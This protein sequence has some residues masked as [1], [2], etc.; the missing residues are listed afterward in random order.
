MTKT[1]GVPGQRP[2]VISVSHR[3]IAPR[4]CRLAAQGFCPSPDR[5]T[6]SQI[7]A[8]IIAW[9]RHHQYS[10]IGLFLCL[11]LADVL[12]TAQKRDNKSL[13]TKLIPNYHLTLFKLLVL[14]S[15][16]DPVASEVVNRPR[17]TSNDLDVIYSKAKTTIS[18]FSLYG[19]R[20]RRAVSGKCCREAHP[21]HIRGGVVGSVM[22]KGL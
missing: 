22:D 16:S 10:V 6:A 2:A 17:S 18:S 4:R 19:Q 12:D 15:R 1:T 14:L 8:V 21:H 5:A 13:L 20:R 7:R 11:F 9:L 3:L